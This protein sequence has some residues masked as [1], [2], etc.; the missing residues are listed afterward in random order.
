MTSI[1]LRANECRVWWIDPTQLSIEKLSSPLT[2]A[3]LRR[4]LTYRRDE[5]RRRNLAGCWLLRTAVSAHLGIEPGEVEVNRTC[6]Y[7]GKPHGKPRIVNAGS[8][9][10]VSLSHSG[11]RVVVALTLAGKVGVDV[12]AVLNDQIRQLAEFTLSPEELRALRALPEDQQHSAFTQ[13]WAWKEAVLKMTGHGLR[14]APKKLGISASWGNPRLVSWPLDTPAD[15][16]QLRTLDVGAGF[17]GA[18]A[19]MSGTGPLVIRQADIT[20]LHRDVTPRAKPHGSGA[21]PV[22]RVA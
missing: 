21:V 16:V 2:S 3:E 14:I 1:A 18:V 22:Q 6:H 13:Y 9:V 5:D 20:D 19:V 12:E 17:A 7:C 11:D 10:H 15:E 4:A 8:D